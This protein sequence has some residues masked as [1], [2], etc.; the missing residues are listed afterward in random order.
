MSKPQVTGRRRAGVPVADPQAAPRR[1]DVHRGRR[2]ATPGRSESVKGSAQ[3][4]AMAAAASGMLLT[5]AMP[6]TAAVSATPEPQVR[7]SAP[8]AAVTAD[9]A[10]L[11]NFSRAGLQSEALDPD[12]KLGEILTASQGG[13]EVTAAPGAL[14]KPVAKLVLTSPFG[15][16]ASPITGAAEL[17]SGQDFAVGCGASVSAAAG[18]KVTFAG[19][20]PY[21]GGNRVVVDH[22]NGLETTYNHLESIS[23][24]V[25]ASVDRGDVIAKA[26]TTG[27][28]TGC[29]LHFEVMVNGET[30][31]PLGW[32]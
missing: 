18:G 10:V 20:H 24:S 23:V 16:R 15:P 29:H 25:G 22:G 12:E 28:S 6:T 17:H 21:G 3:R 14:S 26:G 8:Q 32:L 11:L 30:V 1:R 9:Q 7:Q 2:T 27:A 19:W 31:D 5:V 4:A 13:A